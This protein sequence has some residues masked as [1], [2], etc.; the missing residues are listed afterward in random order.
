MILVHCVDYG[1]YDTIVSHRSS[2]FS[3]QD[4]EEE[5]RYS[6]YRFQHNDTDIEVSTT[7]AYVE[8]EVL[9]GTRPDIE[10]SEF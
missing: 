9:W 6:S 8:T 1:N 10:M 2:F 4:G 3:W 5:T 7:V